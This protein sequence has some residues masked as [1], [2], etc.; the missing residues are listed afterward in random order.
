MLTRLIGIKR[1]ALRMA[2]TFGRATFVNRAITID[3]VFQN[4]GQMLERFILP[5]C[6]GVKSA[7]RFGGGIARHVLDARISNQEQLRFWS[8]EV[9]RNLGWVLGRTGAALVD[10]GEPPTKTA[11]RF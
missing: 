6:G 5:P 8:S 9:F 2:V 7:C 4:L 3:E 1:H 10:L 11:L